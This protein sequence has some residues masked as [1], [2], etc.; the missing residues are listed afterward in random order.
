VLR[1][2]QANALGAER[3]GDARV[4]RS[5]RVRANAEVTNLVC[6]GEK[7]RERVVGGCRLR[8]ASSPNDL[9]HFARRGGQVTAVYT[10]GAAVEG[11]PITFADRRVALVIGNSEYQNATALPNPTKDAQ[12]IATK[13]KEAGFA[14]VSA[15]NDLGNLPFKRAIRQFEDAA[16][17]ADVIVVF[18][19][20]HGIEIRGTNFLIPV[21]AKLA[22]DR[23]AEDEAITLDR[24][25]QSVEGAK[26]LGLVILDACRDNPFARTMKR[27]RTA[28]LRAITPGLSAIEPASSNT[29]IAYAA[30]AGTSAEDGLGEN[31]PFTTALL[32]NLFVKGLDIRLAFGRIRDEVLKTTRGRQEPFVYG[33]I[34]GD[35]ISVVPAPAQSAVTAVDPEGE[36]AD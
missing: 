31:S 2:A 20:G 5:V 14:V 23:D 25:L 4:S 15:H 33:S 13:L 32:N 35:S 16:T 17:D 1:A 29:L 8:G 11:D 19:A 18:Y 36:R 28:A 34:G 26:R 10:S 30:K 27:S 9:H 24:L 22:S 21:D 3:A 7:A 12:A 6:P